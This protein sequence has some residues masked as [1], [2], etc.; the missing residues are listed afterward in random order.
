VS[1]DAPIGRQ[2]SWY[3]T[4]VAAQRCTCTDGACTAHSPPSE[5]HARAVSCARSRCAPPYSKHNV[6]TETAATP[7]E[8]PQETWAPKL[9]SDRPLGPPSQGGLRMPQV[10]RTLTYAAWPMAHRYAQMLGHCSTG[11]CN[12][13]EGGAASPCHGC[14]S[15]RIRPQGGYPRPPSVQSLIGAPVHGNAQGWPSYS[16]YRH[17]QH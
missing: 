1:E 6:G 8:K 14:A 16:S 9:P 3:M 4:A 17:Q 2:H 11:T 7:Q 12:Q 10:A 5:L 13:Q 15:T